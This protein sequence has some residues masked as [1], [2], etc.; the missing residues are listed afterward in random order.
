M[1]TRDLYIQ[2]AGRRF[3]RANPQRMDLLH[4]AEMVRSGEG[5]YVAA[6][7]HLGDAVALYPP[8]PRW[9]FERFGMTRTRLPDGRLVCVAGEHEDHYDPDFCIYNDVVVIGPGEDVAIYGYPEDVFPP[10]D[11][12]T[13]TLV[14]ERIILIGSLGYGG[15]RQDGR[16]QVLALDVKTLAVEAL[17]TGGDGPGWLSRHEAEPEPGGN[18]IR[19][20]GGRVSVGCGK[21][22]SYHPNRRSFRLDLRTLR[23]EAEPGRA[24]WVGP[25]VPPVQW[26]RPWRPMKSQLRARDLADAVSRSVSPW[27]PLFAD[28]HVAVAEN[29]QSGEVLLRPRAEP[30][31]VVV[32]EGPTYGEREELRFERY[33]G[34]ENWL[35]AAEQRGAWW[36]RC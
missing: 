28:D 4:W 18:A 35:A 13:A 11:F 24:R 30:G 15:R 2:Q 29:S 33:E 20:G 14:A 1:L 27:H 12:H 21:D 31:V 10:T 36:W 25:E 22:G 8:E 3:G 17:E 19:V 7:R 6:T 16:T 32:S 9:C 26:P 5:A 23:W 34:I